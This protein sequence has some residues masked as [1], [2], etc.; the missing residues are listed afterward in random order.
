[1]VWLEIVG[2]KN[3][4]KFTGSTPVQ[5]HATCMGRISIEPE[6]KARVYHLQDQLTYIKK[7]SKEGWVPTKILNLVR[8]KL[9]TEEIVEMDLTVAIKSSKSE[10]IIKPVCY[11]SVTAQ[12]N[13]RTQV[14]HNDTIKIGIL[15]ANTPIA[16]FKVPIYDHYS[17]KDSDIITKEYDIYTQSYKLNY[18][19]VSINFSLTEE[20]LEHRRSIR[21]C[22]SNYQELPEGMFFGV[23]SN[24]NIN[25]MLIPG[26]LFIT[27]IKIYFTPDSS[28]NYSWFEVFIQSIKTLKIA[29]KS[30][31][32]ATK[33]L[34]VIEIIPDDIKTVNDKLLTL[35]QDPLKSALEYYAI[36]NKDLLYSGNEMSS[37]AIHDEFKRL[38]GDNIRVS[39]L[40][41]NYEL[42]D[43]Y[44]S[45]LYF[46]VKASDSRIL[47]VA[48]FRSKNRV[49]C[50][51]WCRGPVA[52]YR[53]SQPKLGLGKRSSDDEKFFKEA[54]IKYVIDA[55]PGMN[56]M[57][58]R[59]KGK[60]YELEENYKIPIKFMK[61]HNIHHV[62]KSFEDLTEICSKKQDFWLALH[63]SKWMTH[64]SGILE[65]SICCSN[66]LVIEKASI[67]VHCS[68][69]WDRTSQICALTQVLI[70]KHYRTLKGLQTLITKDWFSFGHKFYDRTFGNDFS[71]IFVLFLDCLYQILLQFPDEFEYTEEY[72]LFLA[73]ANLQGVYGEFLC[74]CE[75]DRN[76]VFMRT[77]SVWTVSNPEF[78]NQQYLPGYYNILPIDSQIFNMKVWKFFTRYN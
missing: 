17:F 66:H 74:N 13:Y 6:E 11:N 67:L 12:V 9:T 42:C 72:L 56:A 16:T 45:L 20:G 57:A 76:D 3:F 18:L 36:V 40:N 63:E 78:Y 59:L 77:Y 41:I 73:D 14:F 52:L 71:P 33:D 29:N 32:I 28:S 58:N 39:Y 23:K 2:M 7:S 60:G 27:S 69:G 1:M 62:S 68:D 25:S 34:R 37:Y 4:E 54:E 61:I 31:I 47:K 30:L 26:N 51:T 43:S 22:I 50:I 65:A 70:D 35:L 53:S 5:Y 24:I 10:K 21:P 64:I 46:P 15:S 49:P 75:K 38:S 19:I 55:R 48:E 44:P 8:E